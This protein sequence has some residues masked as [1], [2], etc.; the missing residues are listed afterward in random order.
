MKIR[1]IIAELFLHLGWAIHGTE[2][3]CG[4][5]PFNWLARRLNFGDAGWDTETGEMNT[6]W[7]KLQY[8]TGNMFIDTG[9]KLMPIDE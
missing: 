4:S 2:C 1:I 6:W 7:S 5:N 3:D 9:T 8:H